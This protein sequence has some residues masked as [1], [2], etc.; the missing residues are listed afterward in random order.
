MKSII[1]NEARKNSLPVRYYTIQLSSYTRLADISPHENITYLH[2]YI[3]WNVQAAS[4]WPAISSSSEDVSYRAIQRNRILKDIH[5]HMYLCTYL[6]IPECIQYTYVVP[7]EC[8]CVCIYD[9]VS[10]QR[11]TMGIVRVWT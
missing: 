3:C 6:R 10:M 9:F 1:A 7:L 5:V 11:M 4:V 2:I 8:L